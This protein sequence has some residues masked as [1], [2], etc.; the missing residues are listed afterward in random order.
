M[1]E[2]ERKLAL[3]F[4][5][6]QVRFARESGTRRQYA[7]NGF[8]F[9]LCSECKGEEE[10][11]H[12]RAAIY[13]RKGKVERYYWR[14]IFKTYCTYILDWLDQNSE[15]TKDIIEFQRK[16]PDIAK[17]L[18][19]EAKQYWQGVNEQKPK[20][21]LK[22]TTQAQFLSS[23]RIPVVSVK[24]EYRQVEKAGQKIGKWMNL[25]GQLV[26]A[27]EVAAEWYQT[28]GYAALR[29]ERKL[30]SVLVGT[31]LTN[32]IQSTSDPRVRTVF[33]NSTK[34]WTPRN[35]KTGRI[36]IL[37]PEDF[38]TVEHYSRRNSAIQTDLDR[39]RESK[40][41]LTLFDMLL[42]PSES[43]RDYLWVND[44]KP[45]GLAQAAL[46]VLPNEVVIAGV[47]WAIQDFWRRQPGW[48]DFLVHGNDEFLFS[49]V[50][51]P[52]DELSHE[53]M[54]WFQWAIEQ[55]GIPCEICRIEKRRA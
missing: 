30:I 19:K 21:N 31:F 16:F 12:P 35:K 38:G 33:R 41:L 52:L 39:M 4:L 25:A 26:S 22:E 37:L 6:H 51:S 43:L 24:A 5:P 49:E 36:S 50:K 1:C 55:A 7:V 14:E 47:E 28:R 44:D 32:S 46:T 20:Y 10:E 3:A 23:V 27:E 40:N 18:K 54:N 45:V 15:Q 34:G 9:R 2:C 17:E 42:H 29:C 13:G 48:P 53:Q 11:A 8:D